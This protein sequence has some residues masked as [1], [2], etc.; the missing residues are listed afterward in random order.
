M[1]SPDT[2]RLRHM[3]EAVA[4]A[5]E[6]A[7]GSQ[8][9]D[10][11]SNLMLAMALARCLEVLG[12]AASKVTPEARLRFSAIPFAKM[13][14]MRNHLIHAYFDIDLDIVWTTVTEDLP[15]LLPALDSALADVDARS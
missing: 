7:A 2:V 9:S 13:V 1:P 5:L 11:T 3:R 12:E 10:L 6:M 15:L 14:S 8:R 4:S